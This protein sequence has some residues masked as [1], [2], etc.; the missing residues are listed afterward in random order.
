MQLDK[1]YNVIAKNK[2]E[3]NGKSCFKIGHSASSCTQTPGF[4]KHNDIYFLD[5]PGLE[6]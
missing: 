5:C 6:D 2:L 4:L 1:D 3:Y